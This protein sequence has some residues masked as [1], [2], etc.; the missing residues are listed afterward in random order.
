MII[1][2]IWE[3]E[4]C[5]KPP[6]SSDRVNMAPV[7]R[8]AA[9]FVQYSPWTHPQ[10]CTAAPRFNGD[11]KGVKERFPYRPSHRFHIVYSFS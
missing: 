8:A 10:R 6:T 9:A 7:K 5:S 11:G 2:N 3:N 1:P 4:K